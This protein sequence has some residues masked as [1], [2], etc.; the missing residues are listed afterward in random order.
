MK[1]FLLSP[2]SIY[3]FLT[4]IVAIFVILTLAKVEAIPSLITVAV[5]T[6]L[7]VSFVIIRHEFIKEEIRKLNKAEQ[8][9]DRY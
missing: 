6:T 9:H 2:Q 8:I 4:L 5:V 3:V 7:Y 1:K